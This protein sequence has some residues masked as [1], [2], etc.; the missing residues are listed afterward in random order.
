MSDIDL[1]EIRSGYNLSKINDNFDKIEEVI[2]EEVVHNTGGNN[3]I[4]QDLDMNSNRLL[5]LPAPASDVEPLRKGDVTSDIT[6]ATVQYVDDSIASLK[7]EVVLQEPTLDS[8][9]ANTLVRE[10]DVVNVKERVSGSGGGATWDY[11]LAS[12]VTPNDL[13]IVACTG[14]PTL[15]LTLRVG[16]TINLSQI[17]ALGDGVVD[18]T[19]AIQ[20]ALDLAATGKRVLGQPGK[21]YL[22]SK[23]LIKS[24]TNS[25]ETNGSTLLPDGTTD[26]ANILA[27]GAVVL[28]GLRTGGTVVSNCKVSLDI[29]MS[30]GD[31]TAILADGS[32]HCLF[33]GNYLHDF[34][35]DPTYNHRG[36]RLSEAA[37]YNIVENN[38]IDSVISPTQRGLLVDVASLFDTTLPFGD[39][40]TGVS[41]RQPDPALSNIITNNRLLNGSYALN[42]QGCE[43]TIFSNNVCLN[44]NHRGIWMGNGSWYNNISNNTINNFTSAAVLLGYSCSFNTISSNSC[45]NEVN[46]GV[47]GEAA[48]NINTGSSNNLIE[49]NNIDAPLNYGVYV[50][51]DSSYNTVSDNKIKGAFVAGIAVQNDWIAVRPPNDFYGRPN[52]ADPTSLLP[53]ISTSWTY[54]DL[55]GTT[56]Q[57]NDI[58]QGAATRNIAAITLIQT[59]N[60]LVG[61]TATKLKDVVVKGNRVLDSTN[62]GYGMYVYEHIAGELEDVRVYDNEW[63]DTLL[64][65]TADF[66]GAN[67]TSAALNMKEVG[68][69]K[70]D[71]NAQL[72]DLLQG[73]AINFTNGDTTPDVTNW[74]FFS[75]SNTSPTTISD[76]DGAKEGKEITVRGDVNTTIQYSSGLIRPKGLTDITGISSNSLVGFKSLAGVWYETW[77]NF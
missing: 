65:N 47:G 39:F 54:N 21:T 23:L 1:K 66:A 40:F 53:P 49:G 5:N 10:G 73:L 17:G 20:R 12:T 58:Y 48:I 19:T 33:T 2:N 3:T 38:T 75:C 74:N 70:A 69:V 6:G 36:I 77:R 50:A 67:P 9:V 29:D 22:H 45:M 8:A 13:D 60:T 37:S 51:T 16:D 52:Y 55:V 27:D 25:F 42:L 30:N 62:V 72:D 44:N 43:R 63:V 46:V 61:A 24:G 4:Y 71:N 68:V 35:D 41:K 15:A 59:R 14:V 64:P 28:Q 18:D 7:S 57:N 76:F 32:T 11:V 56:I 34:T 31:R 26:P